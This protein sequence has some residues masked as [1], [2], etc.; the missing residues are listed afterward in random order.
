MANSFK[1]IRIDLQL[2]ARIEFDNILKR[3]NAQITDTMS[4]SE[5]IVQIYTYGLQHVAEKLEEIER[6]NKLC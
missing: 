4:E 3:I 2:E 5:F 6:A 1:T